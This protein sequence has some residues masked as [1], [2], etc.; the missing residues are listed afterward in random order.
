L[1]QPIFTDQ[2]LQSAR[3]REFEFGRS[4][5]SDES[6]WTIKNIDG[7]FN[8]DP[9]RLTA[10]PNVGDVEIWTIKNNSGGWSHPVHV[11]FEE[12]K[13][14]QR[15][16]R[17]PPLWERY[18]RKDIYRVG[19]EEYG[20]Q[21]VELAIRFREFCGTYMEHC[22]NT[23]HEDTAMLM[24]WDIE[25][26]G[27]IKLMP[28]PLPTWGGMEYV[29]S[30]ML[31]HGR[32]GDNNVGPGGPGGGGGGGGHADP[33]ATADSGQVFAGQ[34]TVISLLANDVS[35]GGTTLE[36][37]SIAIVQAP[38]SGSL[39]IDGAGQAHFMAAP[40]PDS[41]LETFSY[42][43]EDSDG[44]VSNEA[45]VFIQITGNVGGG[46]GGGGQQPPIANPDSAT[47]D[48]G[49]NVQILVLN[50]DQAAGGA[51]LDAGS[52][53]FV[54]LPQIG[55]AQ[56]DGQGLVT[57]IAP[58]VSEDTPASFSYTVTDSNGLVSNI[59]AVSVQIEVPGGGGG[60]GGGGGHGTGEAPRA[61]FDEASVATDSFVDIDLVAND[62]DQDGD[63]DPDSILI[64]QLP[65]HGTVLIL[66]NGWVR[67]TPSVTSQSSDAFSYTVADDEGLRSNA[68]TVGV[69]ITDGGSG[70]G[71]S[72]S[73]TAPTATYDSATAT[74][75]TP[76][77]IDLTANDT[78]PDGDLD[79]DSIAITQWPAH[80][81]LEILSNGSVRYTTNLGHA[82]SDT[83]NY[84]V[85]DSAG[86]VSNIATVGISIQ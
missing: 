9:R 83:F 55:S 8:M 26:P 20:G 76:L 67:Y 51:T 34:S 52:V 48:S 3:R 58:A 65:G 31:E 1:E 72:G 21:T 27:Q 79:A 28:A 24:R 86:N 56:V 29:D 39:S 23:T 85:S 35:F 47:V 61:V 19:P 40:S 60:G 73:G 15:D 36:P 42:W 80:G 64:N 11:H 22:H 54:T 78:D 30:F 81:A 45:T 49:Q 4:S 25:Y 5:G 59:A 74:S 16:G 43:V 13:I 6:P 50:N 12:G 10:A 44:Q 14:L 46:G 41:S 62:S 71:G 18:G 84:T 33:V 68:A 63:L 2:E 17:T 38:G 66:G 82:S 75:G 7:A 70:G 37:I 57:Y 53:A 69:T 32:L 77:V